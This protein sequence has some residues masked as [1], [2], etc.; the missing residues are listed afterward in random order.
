MCQGGTVLRR[1]GPAAPALHGRTTPAGALWVAWPKRTSGVPTDLDED[2]VRAYALAHIAPQA[3][4]T[5]LSRRSC[6]PTVA[7]PT[8]ASLAPYGN[9]SR[10][11]CTR[12]PQE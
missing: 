4:G 7:K 2:T 8:R 1:R 5:M 3:I 6:R 12:P 11:S 10:P 9:Q